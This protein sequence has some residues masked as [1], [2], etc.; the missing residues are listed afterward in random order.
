MTSRNHEP[1]PTPTHSLEAA[2]SRAMLADRHWFRRQLRAIRQAEQSGRP[3]DRNLNRLT[4]ALEKSTARRERRERDVPAIA[5]DEELPI[6]SRR[7]EIAQ[8]IAAHQVVVVSG[9]TGSG[10]STQLPKI[11]LELGR[12]IGGF[13]GHTQPR[14]IA[15]RS[16]AARIAEELGSPL[17]KDV[18]YKIRF[19]DTT[20]PATY[21]KLMTDGILLA[22]SQADRFLNQ[23]DTIIIDEAHE[24]S[25]N[26]DFLLGLLKRLLPKRP[27]LKL[28]ITSATIDAERFSEHFATPQGPAPVIEVSGRTY[29]VEVRYRPLDER[30]STAMEE[31]GAAGENGGIASREPPRRRAVDESDADV[32]WQQG[33]LDAVDELAGIDRGDILIFMPTERDIHE[34]AKTLRGRRIPGDEVG[35]TTEILPLYARLSAKDQNRVF[36]PHPHRRIVIATNVAESSLTVPGIRSVI[37]PGTARISRYSPRSQMQRLPI[38]PISQASADQ[39]KGRC[40]RVGPGICI[41][42]YSGAD[43]QNRDAFTAPEIQRTNLASVI[44]QTKALKLGAIDE[45]PFLDPPKPAAIRDGY[46]TLFEL[47]ALDERQEL[48]PLGERLSRIPTDPRIARM[49]IAGHEENC[50]HDVLIIAAALEVQDPR[51]RPLEKQ[52]AADESHARFADENSDFLAYLKLWNFYHK[53]KDELSRNQ[54]RKACRQNFLS[55]NRL[56]EWA[57]VHLQLLQLVE[58]AGLKP[59]Q[60][61]RKQAARSNAVDAVPEPD[62]RSETDPQSRG[63][64]QYAAIHRALLTG[65]LSNVA[66]KSETYEYTVAGGTKVTLWP[67]SGVFAKKPKW[68]MAAEVVETTRR[69]VRTVARINP[70]WIEALAPHLTKRAYSE[71]HWRRGSASAMAYE[72][73]SL[74]GLTIVPRR[75]VRYGPIDPDK[76][77]E[78]LIQQGLVEAEFDNPPAFLEHNQQFLRELEALQA[79]ARRCDL[80]IDEPM[81]FEF[82]DRRVPSDVYD[83][84]RLRKWLRRAERKNPRVLRMA[85]SDFLEPETED[86][87][88]SDYPD[89]I[90][91]RQMKL[92]LEYHLEPGSAEDGITVVVPQEG[93]NQLDPQRLGWLV[94]GL[95]EEK[96]VALIKALPKPIRRNLVPAPDTA[97]QVL[98]ELKFGQGSFDDEVARI[99]SRIAGEPI[100]RE[101]FETDKLPPH[102][103]M[104]VKVVDA[105]GEAV[106]SGRDLAHLRQQLGAKASAS[107]SQMSRHQWNRDGVTAWDFGDLPAQID[108]ERGGVALK[109]FPTL[110]DCGDS[111]SLRL[112]DAPEKAAYELRAG[113]RRLFL[114]ATQRELKKPID[115]LPNLNQWALNASTLR[116]GGKLKQWLTE[117]AADRAFLADQPLPRTQAEFEQRRKTGRERIAVAVQDVVAL[118]GPLL[119]TYQGA[120]VALERRVQPQWKPAI[121]DMQQQLSHLTEPGFLVR[122]PWPWLVQYPR[123]FR[124][125]Q[126]R[127]QKLAQG[128]LPRDRRQAQA[129]EPLWKAYLQR[130]A[131]H[132]ERGPYDPQ[133]AHYRWMLEEYRVSLFAQQ[134]GTAI[135]VS[136]KRLAEQWAKVRP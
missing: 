97:R 39:R 48:T 130:A 104:N 105:K 128:G 86:V 9:E 11:C 78:L 41:R 70:D 110:I 65:L 37:D 46:K 98:S 87:A 73:V 15:A 43:Y 5:Y 81:Q 101:T 75:R 47:G 26:I 13:I 36:Q 67:G 112:L 53:L 49:I 23:Y 134:L 10:K 129:I 59:G 114:L 111:V 133:L 90:A 123:Y 102:L 122:T 69:Y 93:L 6:A 116:E 125:I 50:L 82:Y 71:P 33:I 107:F 120:K 127:V 100:S 109:G 92:P 1:I 106:A 16:V 3:F 68:V 77:R 88:A 99:L 96:I 21:I 62:A 24:R 76:S 132:R 58:G 54:L 27:E 34:L 131:Q 108:L 63:A 113:I 22:E 38:E 2:I 61:A 89:A 121:D 7:Q 32:D 79:K 14:R 91:V 94:P 17:G 119:E 117:L 66:F 103:R 83:G 30:R 74:F 95:L 115:W 64:D 52:Q 25:L 18:G 51:E 19:T 136:D 124:A 12:G 84:V 126:V 28:I 40:G 20:S 85:K 4:A 31:L 44:L 55:Y 45:F 60:S 8:A 29:P 57:D 56:R 118:I 35:R 72:R 135:S 80:V 42:L